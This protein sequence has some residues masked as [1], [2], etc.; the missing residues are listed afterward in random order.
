MAEAVGRRL[1][2]MSVSRPP[3]AREIGAELRQVR[4]RAGLTLRDLEKVTGHGNAK[5]S[6]WENGRRLVPAEELAQLLEALSASD[7]DRERILGMR[8]EAE[9]P[10][11]LMAGPATIGAQLTELIQLEQSA[12]RIVEVA[13]LLIPGL[14][15]TSG[16]ARAI[17]EGYPDTETRTALR[18]GRRDLL[19]RHGAPVEFHALIDDEVLSRHIAPPPVMAEQMRHLLWMAQ[20]PNVTIQLV[21]STHDGYTPMLD[22]PFILMEFQTTAPIVHLEHHSASANL[23][24]DKDVRR[25][26]TAVEWITNAAMTPER[27]SEVIA[28]LVKG[29]ET[30]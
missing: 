5:I 13:P 11:R 19:T 28:E 8:R 22:G 18:M 6:M 21:H 10:G 15:Q 2:D 27:S 16:Y 3:T 20:R 23:W 4:K 14:L 7:A 9:G 26:Q 25:F 17:F 12:R 24:D 29:M 1:A 30:T